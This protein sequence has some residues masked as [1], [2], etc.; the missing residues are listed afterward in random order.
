MSVWV[1]TGLSNSI[2][3]WCSLLWLPWRAFVCVSMCVMSPTSLPY[4]M[5]W[6]VVIR[7]LKTTTQLELAVRSNSVS[8]SWGMF[9][10]ISL[11]QWIRSGQDTKKTKKQNER[12]RQ[13]YTREQNKEQW[14]EA[15]KDNPDRHNTKLLFTER[16]K[17]MQTYT[18]SKDQQT[19]STNFIWILKWKKSEGQVLPTEQFLVFFW[20]LL[21]C[22]FSLS[23]A[24]SQKFVCH[25]FTQPGGKL[26]LRVYDCQNII[27]KTK[28][29]N[30]KNNLKIGLLQHIVLHHSFN[31]PPKSGIRFL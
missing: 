16:E 23:L 4:I 20:L 17:K 24:R 7:A 8:A 3:Y 11:V 10:F 9:T 14:W 30:L 15:F 29:A 6:W 21:C 26:N 22:T 1:E 27:K 5:R 19:Q 25:S 12:R 18:H 31:F 13:T 28:L 2:T